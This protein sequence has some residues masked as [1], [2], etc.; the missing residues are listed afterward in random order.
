[1]TSGSSSS[2]T[3]AHRSSQCDTVRMPGMHVADFFFEVVIPQ[4]HPCP[5]SGSL[6]RKKGIFS[7]V[8]PPIVPAGVPLGDA[9]KALPSP[10]GALLEVDERGDPFHR[11]VRSSRSTSVATLFIDPGW[12]AMME[13]DMRSS[14]PAHCMRRCASCWRRPGGWLSSTALHA[15]PRARVMLCFWAMS[16]AETAVAGSLQGDGVSKSFCLV[17]PSQSRLRR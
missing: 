13:T 1:M 17:S 7:R 3:T 5:L 14:V 8:A 15:A 9:C 16:F 12:R 2:S 4:S 6:Y 11:V 10:C